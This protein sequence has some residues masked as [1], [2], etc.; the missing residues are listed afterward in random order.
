[1]EKKTVYG[2]PLNPTH[3]LNELKGASFCVSYATRAKL[4]KQLDQAI[5]LVGK[6]GI[7]LVDNGAFS[8]HQAGVDTMNDEAYLNG[9]AD[10]ANDIAD[11]CPQAI[12]VFPDVIG[13][14]AEQNR[15]LVIKSMGLVYC[16][17][18]MPIWHM[19]E[20]IEYL[21]WMCKAFN[22]IGIGSSAQYF[23]LGPAWHDR[24]KEA[25]AAIDAWEIETGLDRP[26][27]HMMRAQKMAHLYPFDSSDSTNVAV[28]H[29][30]QRRLGEDLV[31]FAAR[32]DG[33]IQKSAG[34]IAPHQI[35]APII[36][37]PFDDERAA[38]I[39]TSLG[40]EVRAYEEKAA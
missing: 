36:S 18:A 40:F 10:W 32:I 30:R 16:D 6:D 1:M 38:E 3:L 25:L 5:E 15:E 11:R 34:P 37:R 29:G 7:L 21:L 14:T 28:N 23:D 39:L 4:G 19:H 20:P 8:A 12:I 17:R 26:R 24:I 31:A 22:Y 9:F 13:G 27:I 2:L 35:A 33:K